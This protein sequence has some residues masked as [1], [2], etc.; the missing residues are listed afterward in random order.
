VNIQLNIVTCPTYPD[1]FIR[2]NVV[3]SSSPLFTV[4]RYKSPFRRN[5]YQKLELCC[6]FV[7]ACGMRVNAS[8]RDT[9]N[10]SEC[11]RP[12]LNAPLFT[13]DLVSA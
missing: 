6:T 7:S 5:R 8:I 1:K 13:A 12:T 9:I 2:D 10:A 4:T 11:D 3:A